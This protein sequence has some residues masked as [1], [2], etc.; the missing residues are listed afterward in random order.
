MSFTIR[1]VTAR[2]SGG[3]IVRL[4]RV[5]A[6]TARIG[7]GT[8]CEIHLPDL[9]VQLHQATVSFSG[10]AVSIDAVGG[11]QF[12]WNGSAVTAAR[13]NP[14]DRPILHFGSHT[15]AFAPGEQPGDL[16]VTLSR[17]IVAG[18]PA[19]Q[20]RLKRIFSLT[21]TLF[22]TRRAAWLLGLAILVACL[23]A[24]IGVFVFGLG[25]AKI[26]PDQQWSPGPLSAGHGFLSQSCEACHQQAF[27]SVKDTACLACHR[28]VH[29]QELAQIAARVN[30][31]GSPFE[32]VP[33]PDHASQQRLLC[34]RVDP[35]NFLQRTELTF[36][37]LFGHPALRC[38]ECHTEHVG[39]EGE[40]GRPP[41]P[42]RAQLKNFDCI[43]CHRE[44]RER[45]RDSVVTDAPGWARHP[46]FRPLIRV[47]A[48][49]LQARENLAGVSQDYS[50]I[51]FSHRQHLN[52]PAVIDE[53]EKLG[54]SHFGAP[55]T[56]RNC[57]TLA[58]D[59]RSFVPIDM[60]R[61][62]SSCHDLEYGEAATGEAMTLKHGDP[63][64]VVR[65]LTIALNAS[66]PLRLAGRRRPG[67]LGDPHRD[68]ISGTE[69]LSPEQVKASIQ[70]VFRQGGLCYGCHAFVQPQGPES[71]VYRVLPKQLTYG[72]VGAAH[73]FPWSAF[74]H[75]IP[76]HRQ[77]GR[78]QPT[79][80]NCHKTVGSNKASYMTL[81]PVRECAGCHGATRV[82][83]RTPASADCM[84]CHGYHR[85]DRPLSV[86][87]DNLHR[88][89]MTAP[90]Q[91]AR[92]A[93]G[94]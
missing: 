2:A 21:P 60:R 16:S 69:R 54:A 39:L 35:G 80:S 25:A 9:A 46:E 58:G 15:L 27:V 41:R 10:G 49:G 78:G 92:A 52:D 18:D 51:R 76:E 74:D 72:N 68:P 11:A 64:A 91:P 17:A 44:I 66:Q 23:L 33:A 42:V 84:E 31:S 5:D 47:S 14:D 7:R 90:M 43:A 12:D 48:R 71:L 70:G 55:L 40:H 77:D 26:R 50:G 22:S 75:G 88:M 73:Y 38:A 56:C 63:D 37:E 36:E 85:F 45:L 24:P 1:T 65:Q 57:H 82:T 20:R 34:A 94:M 67:Y 13:F 29:R 61:D 81:P 86:S 32:P 4:R 89:R 28:T 53:A 62:C 83:S 8:D 79:C 59:G 93:N 87:F 19:D 30:A 3:E 6:N